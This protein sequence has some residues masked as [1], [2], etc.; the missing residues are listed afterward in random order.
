MRGFDTLWLPRL[1]D[2]PDITV[3]LIRSDEAPGGVSELAVPPV[4][5]AVANAV[6]AA[7]GVRLRALPLLQ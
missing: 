1:A 6:Q 7:T 4:A 2:T 5:P 3:E